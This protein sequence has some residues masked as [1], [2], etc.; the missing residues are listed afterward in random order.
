M[1]RSYRPT[2][3]PR[4][5]ARDIPG[6]FDVLFPQLTPGVVAFFN[7]ET[8]SVEGCDDVAAEII[9]ASSL[10]KAMLFELSIAA[11]E[12]LLLNRKIDWD[13]SLQ[14]AVARQRRHFDAKIPAK[15]ED[16]DIVAA[17]QVAE[18]VAAMLS[19]I[20][21]LFRAPIVISPRIPGYQW[22]ASGVGDFSTGTALIEVKCSHKHFSSPDYRQV[23]MYW[24]LTYA[25][26]V[27]SRVE[28]WTECILLNPRTNLVFRTT[29]DD[30]VRVIAAGRSKVEILELFSAMVS[31]HTF[32]LLS[33]I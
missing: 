19:R 5:V 29:F 12:Q 16:A 9:D 17:S 30:L 8:Y 11:G 33:P 32:R 26:A 13:A 1:S 27:E 24:L 25:A 10:H 6:I 22:I 23:V 21:D 2:N 7:R 4:S 31:D 14:I 28:E 20:A 18:N 3:D 15:L